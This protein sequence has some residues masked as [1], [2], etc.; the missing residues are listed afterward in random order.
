M[1]FNAYTYNIMNRC[2]W[3]LVRLRCG[4]HQG[5]GIGR[6]YSLTSRLDGLRSIV[7]SVSGSWQ[8]LTFKCIL[9]LRVFA[10]ENRN[11]R[12]QKRFLKI[13]QTKA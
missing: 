13:D 6:K 7:C 1:A 4:I 5:E 9:I 3:V 12:Y 11:Q 10:L 8:N 2:D